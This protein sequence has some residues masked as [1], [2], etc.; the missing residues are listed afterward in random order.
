MII[1]R[2]IIY[3]FCPIISKLNKF[4]SYHQEIQHIGK[5]LRNR[6]IYYKIIWGYYFIIFRKNYGM[7]VPYSPSPQFTNAIMPIQAPRNR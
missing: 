5:L 2:E 6:K 7:I 3:I 4:I 1:I